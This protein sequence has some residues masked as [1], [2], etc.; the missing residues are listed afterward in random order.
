MNISNYDAILVF[1]MVAAASQIYFRFSVWW[2]HS[3]KKVE[4][5]P[6]TKFRLEI[7][8]PAVQIPSLFI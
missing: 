3:F 7:S 1:K 4:I 6:H 2:R 5:Y 8:Q